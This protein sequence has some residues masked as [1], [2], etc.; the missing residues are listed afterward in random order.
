MK[1]ATRAAMPLRLLVLVLGLL[2]VGPR[3]GA[4]Q[5]PTLD[6][7]VHPYVL[8][9]VS[10]SVEGLLEKVNVDRG[11][12][13]RQGQVIATLESSVERANL[14]LAQ[15]RAAVESATKSSE[16][17]LEFGVRRFV[18]TADLFKQQLVPGKEMDE[19]ETGKILA[20]IGVI[21]AKENRRIAELEAERA[22]A[23]LAQ[24]TI[25]SP[26]TGVVIER[27]LVGGEFVRGTA[28]VKLAQIDPLRVEVI[29]PVTLLGRLPLGT[30]AEV[31][32]EAPLGSTHTAT[33][34]VVDRVVDAASG[35][36]GVRLDLANPGYRL[37]A[38]LKCKARF[39][40]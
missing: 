17:R 20:E 11:D 34:A 19:A 16:V 40:R 9:A 8:V 32:M 10:A 21:E 28:I 13:V 1:G 7:V 38:G 26:I 25:R 29:A 27:A 18:R 22:Q 39:L 5:P 30:R 37:P 36:F 33:V 23:A 14:A 2:A 35:T 3:P 24:R 4:T 6:C 12:I 15:A 31:T